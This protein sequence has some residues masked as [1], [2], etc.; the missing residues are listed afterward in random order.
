MPGNT[1]HVNQTANDDPG[2][3][4]RDSKA[5]TVSARYRTIV[6]RWILPYGL[7]VVLLLGFTAL[8]EDAGALSGLWWHKVLELPLVLY[9][10]F[11]FSQM[12]RQDRWG[13]V[14]AAVPIFAGYA[15]MDLYYL[16]FGRVF[17][18]S[19][20]REVPELLVVLPWQL[21]AA[22]VAGFLLLVIVFLLTL[23]PRWP[24]RLA[25][26]ALPLAALVARGLEAESPDR[27]LRLAALLPADGAAA[28]AVARKLRLSNNEATRLVAATEGRSDLG[29]SATPVDLRRRIYQRGQT[30]VADALR[31]EWAG[32]LAAGERVD[33][34]PALAIADDWRP[35]NFPLQ[36][37]D[38]LGLGVAAGAAVGRLLKAV[39]DWWID[40]DFE[41]GRKACLA[42]LQ[43][44]IAAKG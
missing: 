8:L 5:S 7:F 33:A 28:T 21:S 6:Q 30:A 12:L 27:L 18:L 32:R 23:R 17:R 42:K 43:E 10:Y 19:E 40:Q 35:P 2:D 29:L 24:L 15:L 4:A 41:P 11:L 20:L 36:G 9:L 34:Q 38:V 1:D 44:L 16:L 13:A 37:R 31:L 26:A 22:L 14:V 3:S 39:E 25:L